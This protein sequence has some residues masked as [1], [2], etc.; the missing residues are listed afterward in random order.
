MKRAIGT[1]GWRTRSR[2]ILHVPFDRWG[3]LPSVPWFEAQHA[4]LV[5]RASAPRLPFCQRRKFQNGAAVEF[6]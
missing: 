5:S 2:G 6:R 3:H 4:I 1:K